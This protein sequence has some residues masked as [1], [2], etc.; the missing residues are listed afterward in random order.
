M[1]ETTPSGAA[2]AVSSSSG[3]PV[4]EQQPWARVKRQPKKSSPGRMRKFESVRELLL[5]PHE[6]EH[7]DKV[8]TATLRL[9]CDKR[10]ETGMDEAKIAELNEIDS[11]LY[12]DRVQG[13]RMDGYTVLSACAARCHNCG[14]VIMMHRLFW[15]S[16]MSPHV[17]PSCGVA[18]DK[19]AK[20]ADGNVCLLLDNMRRKFNESLTETAIILAQDS[21]SQA[22]TS[23]ATTGASSS[24]SGVSSSGGPTAAAESAIVVEQLEETA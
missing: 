2:L 1:S 12:D 23:D 6:R 5:L 3:E 16:S 17:C 13:M 22:S 24:S 7:P 19:V 15:V 20:R 8:K 14:G 21:P 4:R 9:W 18:K 11:E 10:D